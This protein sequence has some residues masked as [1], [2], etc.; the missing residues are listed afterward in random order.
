MK[1]TR[2]YIEELKEAQGC[3]SRSLTEAGKDNLEC[4]CKLLNA[5]LNQQ[6]N[7]LKVIE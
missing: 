2:D 3:P 6:P 5:I 4:A 1:F 7:D